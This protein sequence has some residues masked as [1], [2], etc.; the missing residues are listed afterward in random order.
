M[1]A[2]K[3]DKP[4]RPSVGNLSGNPSKKID[5]GH[6]ADVAK[7]A[8]GWQPKNTL[9][10][11]KQALRSALIHMS[12]GFQLPKSLLKAPH[13]KGLESFSFTDGRKDSEAMH[14]SVYVDSKNNK[15]L[16]HL[17]EAG[18]GKK[19]VSTWHALALSDFK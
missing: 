12:Q 10:L 9:S 14:F 6:K 8:V 15:L 17:K 2:I 5:S 4:V 18:V 19:A 1:A 16:V 13:T 3:F 11:D 7:S